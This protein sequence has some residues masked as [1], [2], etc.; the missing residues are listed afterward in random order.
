MTH[1]LVSLENPDNL[2]VGKSAERLSID[3]VPTPPG[4]ASVKGFYREFIEETGLEENFQD[5]SQDIENPRE[6][7]LIGEQVRSSFKEADMPR[8]LKNS[9]AEAYNELEARVGVADPEVEIITSSGDRI[10]DISGKSELVES[11]KKAFAESHTN[12]RIDNEGLRDELD[13]T[14][15]YRGDPEVSGKI[16]TREPDSGN[17][18]ISLVKTGEEEALIFNERPALIDNS[19]AVGRNKL[20]ELA[21]YGNRIEE[22]FGASVVNWRI[23]QDSKKIYIEGIRPES[24]PNEIPTYT[25]Y[26]LEEESEK[27]ASGSPGSHGIASGRAQV[28]DSP[29]QSDI[30]EGGVLV[31]DSTGPEW[32]DLIDEASA[33]VTNRGGIESHAAV[34]GRETETPVVVGCGDATSRVGGKEVTVDG[35][36]GKVWEG[37][38]EYL[39]D[40]HRAMDRPEKSVLVN[41]A[42]AE[43]APDLAALPV[44]GSIFSMDFV[45]KE[46]GRH[47]LEYVEE[48]E[49]KFIELVERKT[50][51]VIS[52][53]HPDTTVIR[54][55]DL[56]ARELKGLKAGN[57]HEDYLENPR[58]GPRGG[59]RFTDPD[60]EK[61][62]RAEI[63]GI[64]KAIKKTRPEDVRI[65]V[66]FCRTLQEAK[67]VKAI[68]K[69][70]GLDDEAEILLEIDVAANVFCGELDEYFDGFTVNPV[71]LSRSLHYSSGYR[72]EAL[73]SALETVDENLEAGTGL[74][75][76]SEEGLDLIRSGFE[77]VS[78]PRN[79]VLKVNELLAESEDGGGVK[80]VA[81]DLLGVIS[82]HGSATAE[83]LKE[84]DDKV[85]EELRDRALD[86]LAE[87]GK[88]EVQEDETGETRYSVEG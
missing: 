34:Y 59:S 8:D 51:L 78:A 30:F 85:G 57:S 60:Y 47:P 17:S 62:F 13:F 3:D 14:V 6:I 7:A 52:S 81:S 42:E 55:P 37:A 64:Q 76:E 11:V 35:S 19:T 23:E 21:K 66:P 2:N 74:M 61:V 39:V 40:E 65:Q 72:T 79:L 9:L 48:D 33:V 88:V 83:T 58:T 18:N 50:S 32:E 5:I 63:E 31:V 80:D 75:M 49:E 26:R 43:D 29:K 87:E 67:R 12:K 27:V 46:A 1:K 25:N 70:E 45:I 73:K 41:V 38:L 15:L 56:T 36:D 53:F 16:Y 77:F 20:K 10:K 69:E 71:E 24:L 4:F 44:D 68:L 22:Q 82:E 84:Y 54:L 28:L 86:W